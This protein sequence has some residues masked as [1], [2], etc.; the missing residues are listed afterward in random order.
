MFLRSISGAVSS[1]RLQ[2]A[3]PLCTGEAEREQCAWRSVLLVYARKKEEVKN[4]TKKIKVKVANSEKSEEWRWQ[5]NKRQRVNDRRCERG[6]KWDKGGSTGR[7]GVMRGRKD[8][9]HQQC[10]LKWSE[11]SPDDVSLRTDL[12]KLARGQAGW[13]F[14]D[15]QVMNSHESRPA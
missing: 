15:I 2:P 10:T 5:E 1:Y 9:Y 12:S 13:V 7:A 3:P 4:K 6:T 8:V 11:L 14:T